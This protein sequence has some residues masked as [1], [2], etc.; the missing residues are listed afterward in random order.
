MP[1]I[2]LIKMYLIA[3]KYLLKVAFVDHPFSEWFVHDV[4]EIIFWSFAFEVVEWK[5]GFAN[6]LQFSRSFP[7]IFLLEPKQLASA[8]YVVL[9]AIKNS[10][11]GSPETVIVPNVV[12]HFF[13]LAPM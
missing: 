3:N 5:N 1:S 10:S 12:K 8:L 11:N 6:F 7:L 4:G 9:L 2:G 13:S